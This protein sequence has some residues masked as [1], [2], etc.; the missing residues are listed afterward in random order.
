MGNCIGSRHVT[1]DKTYIEKVIYPM[2]LVFSL[3]VFP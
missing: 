2:I 1:N 3:K